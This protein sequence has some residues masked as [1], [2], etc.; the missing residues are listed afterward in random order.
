MNSGQCVGQMQRA[1]LV[2]NG[3]AWQVLV[4]GTAWRR[5]PIDD[6]F[7]GDRLQFPLST[8]GMA[9]MR[10]VLTYGRMFRDGRPETHTEPLKANYEVKIDVPCPQ[11][12]KSAAHSIEVTP[13]EVSHCGPTWP[14]TRSCV[15][16]GS[17]WRQE[18]SFPELFHDQLL[19]AMRS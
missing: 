10:V 9:V 14:L 19:A 8:T 17:C 5:L 12:D 11:C 3:T 15:D 16:C 6:F 13:Q 2:R 1:T 7:M 18:G 4:N